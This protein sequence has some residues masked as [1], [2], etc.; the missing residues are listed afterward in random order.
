MVSRR[1][2]SDMAHQ[3]ISVGGSTGD[4]TNDLTSCDIPSS[5]ESNVSFIGVAWSEVVGGC[6]TYHNPGCGI[7]YISGPS[8]TIDIEGYPVPPNSLVYYGCN[9]SDPCDVPPGKKIGGA[10]NI[11]FPEPGTYVIACLSGYIDGTGFHV[12]KQSNQEKHNVTCDGG[13]GECSDHQTQVA[14]ITHDCY[15][16]N[17]SCHRD[18]PTCDI[19]NNQTDCITYG[20]YWYN[21]SCHSGIDC[22]AYTNA[23]DCKSYNCYWYNNSCHTNPPLCNELNNSSDCATY[24]CYWWGNSCHDTGPECSP[25]GGTKCINK[26]LYTCVNGKWQLTESNSPQCGGG[27]GGNGGNGGGGTIKE[28]IP[29]IGLMLI[30]PIT[31]AVGTAISGRGLSNRRD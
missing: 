19:L 29:I 1:S 15:W 13:T 6:T 18:P 14:C 9:P 28:I 12:E 21:N 24:G 27:N 7:G 11:T 31:A 17:N 30:F 5:A 10:L 16:Y 8:A 26:D 20:C 3:C 22:T 2:Y 23:Y 25:D 4:C